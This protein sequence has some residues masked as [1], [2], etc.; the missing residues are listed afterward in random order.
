MSLTFSKERTAIIHSSWHDPRKIRE[1][2]IVGS[3]RMI[4]YD[5]IA[6]QEKI[7]VFDVRVERPPHYDTFAEF[8]YSYHYG[9]TYSPFIRQ[10]EPLKIECAH[11]LDS[12]RSGMTPLTSGDAG[13][14][15]VRILEASS[16]SLKA[17]GAPINIWPQPQ[18]G[19]SA[20]PFPNGL[21][22]HPFASAMSRPP[23][24]VRAAASVAI[25]ETEPARNGNGREHKAGAAG[26]KGGSTRNGAGARNGNGVVGAHASTGGK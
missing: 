11:F 20:T 4:V 10:D 15:V 9:D 22:R 14:E 16:E 17:N 2:T 8:H 3:K 6:T 12:I 7:K 5:D 26:R 18:R 13:L 1:M 25:A 24:P 19:E 21:S 23:F